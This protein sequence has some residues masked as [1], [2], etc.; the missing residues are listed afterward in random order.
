LIPP[1]GNIYIIFNRDSETYPFFCYI[2]MLVF[3]ARKLPGLHI[4]FKSSI[5]K[6]DTKKSLENLIL[7]VVNSLGGLHN[8]FPMPSIP[9]SFISFR[10]ST[11]NGA[12]M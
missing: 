10:F 9:I 3:H 6:Q 11:H 1:T 2:G 8:G 4:P 7:P 12:D 5:P